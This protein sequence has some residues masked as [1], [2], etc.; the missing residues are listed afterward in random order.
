MQFSVR[1][2]QEIKKVLLNPEEKVPSKTYYMLRGLPFFS[3][4]GR[5]CDLTIIPAFNLGKEFNKTF[6]HIHS[7]QEEELYKLLTGKA[8]FVLQKMKKNS[9]NHIEEIKLIHANRGDY[10]KITSGWYHET[11][12]I[13]KSPLVLINWLP[14]ET[15]NDYSL[16]EKQQ[17]FGYYIIK[18][19]SGY[20][21]VK[22]EN[23]KYVPEPKVIK[24]PNKN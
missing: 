10:I 19:K 11:I 5:R 21:L 9:P 23:Y 3:K 13:G 8:L 6:G 17:G 12:N 2:A 16:I 4:K 18:A 20:Q 15:K 14:Q 1:K 24:E 22:N 7:K